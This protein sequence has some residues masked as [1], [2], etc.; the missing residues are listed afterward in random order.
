[1]A[2]CV[3]S[4]T[5]E[6][7]PTLLYGIEV[8]YYSLIVCD[9]RN[10]RRKNL[11]ELSKFKCLAV[12][13]ELPGGDVTGLDLTPVGRGMPRAPVPFSAVVGRHTAGVALR[14][15]L[16]KHIHYHIIRINMYNRITIIIYLSIIVSKCRPSVKRNY[17][18]I[19]L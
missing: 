15:I 2:N 8:S 4:S 17:H 10:Y 1:L 14:V 11:F 3:R 7:I 19:Q 5:V 18:T 12:S 6:A 16:R 9:Y 13:S